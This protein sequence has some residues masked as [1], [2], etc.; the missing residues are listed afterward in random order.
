MPLHSLRVENFKGISESTDF[1]LAPLTLFLGPN[2]SG[3]SSCIHALAA[4][5]Q[6]LKLGDRS[7]A[8]VLDHEAAHVHLGR[9]IEVVHSKKYSDEMKI[10]LGLGP[11]EIP[12]PRT[13]ARQPIRAI[14]GEARVTYSFKSNRRTQEIL[15]MSA[16]LAINDRELRIVPYKAG[17]YRMLDTGTGRLQ[18]VRRSNNFMFETRFAISPRAEALEGAYILRAIQNRV[19]N[20]LLATLYL[21][22]FRQPPRRRYPFRGSRPSE[23]GPQGDAA[24]ALLA[25]E[26]VQSKVRTHNAQI[27]RWLGVL[28][29]GNSIAVG[30]VGTSDLFGVDITLPDDVK[31]PIADL[32]YGVS[33]VLPV[34]A[35]CSFALKGSTLLFEQPELHLHPGAAG[36]LAEIFAEVIEKKEL[37]IVAETHSEELFKAIMT[38]LTSGRLTVGQVAAYDVRR[39]DKR[40]VYKRIPFIKTA[41]GY[42]ADYTWWKGLEQ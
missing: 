15:L 14:A 32:G 6:S 35:Q 21:G 28:R 4:L 17:N 24:V 11:M 34:L 10:G 7:A 30:R 5:S 23:V 16:V 3:K 18:L 31:L 33:Q 39:E 8:L 13:E 12:L 42:M 1:E 20:D 40:S 9:F 38:L 19:G 25:A 22:P 2:S 36:R 29:L 41:N 37:R 26:H 27:A